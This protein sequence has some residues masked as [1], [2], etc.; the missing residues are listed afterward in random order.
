MSKKVFNVG[1]HPIVQIYDQGPRMEIRTA[2]HDIKWIKI[3]IV[4]VGYSNIAANNPV[5]VL[6]TVEKGNVPFWSAQDSVR[7]C[8]QILQRYI[9]ISR[10]Y[11][12]EA[13]YLKIQS[14]GPCR[15]DG[16]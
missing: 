14:R 13:N 9:P 16:K 1:K 10:F 4:R 12:L 3:D 11:F 15:N 5:V 8:R 7:K 2:L 6:I